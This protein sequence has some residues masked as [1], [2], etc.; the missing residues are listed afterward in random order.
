MS[1]TVGVN[2]VA[3]DYFIDKVGGNGAGIALTGAFGSPAVS[4][5]GTVAGSHPDP[6]HAHD[7]RARRGRR[8]QLGTGRFGKF[9]QGDPQRDAERRRPPEQ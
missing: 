4:V 3:A 8:R 9:R 6:R 2:I 1:D 7:L 5:S